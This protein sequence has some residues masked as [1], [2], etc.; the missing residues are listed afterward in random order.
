MMS[1]VTVSVFCDIACHLGE[2]PTYDPVSQT[3]FWFDIVERKL[4]EKRWPDGETTVH[5]LPE[6]A[7]ALA[8]VDDDRQLIVTETGL[9]LCDA[10]SGKMDL[11][12]PIEADNPATRSNDARV[13]P[14]GAFWIG[15]M[16]KRA[17]KSAG[18]IYWFFRG[19]L[20][21]LFPDISIP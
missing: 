21:R 5:D 4:L 14:C 15:T 6:M 19:E 20:R 10:R 11:L 13:H 3:V 17:E 9:H 18:S 1:D 16:G 7:S 8:V 2:G 12:A